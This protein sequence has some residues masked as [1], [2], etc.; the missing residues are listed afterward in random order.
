M[1]VDEAGHNQQRG[2]ALWG[3]PHY[4]VVAILV[5]TLIAIIGALFTARWSQ[6]DRTRTEAIH[7]ISDAEA[8]TLAGLSANLRDH[9]DDQSAANDA[10]SA[11]LIRLRHEVP[12]N[13]YACIEGLVTRAKTAPYAT[14]EHELRAMAYIER[15]A[16]AAISALED[17]RV[18]ATFLYQHLPYAGFDEG[19][20]ICWG[21]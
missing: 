17:W 19:E 21:S 18:P 3:L 13:I 8:Q 7:L 12:Q 6:F 10:M 16:A 15:Q 2:K 1:M 5:P 20:I 11:S 4:L 9:L 14:V